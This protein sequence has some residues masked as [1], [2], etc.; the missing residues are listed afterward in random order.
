MKVKTNTEL[1]EKLKK[2]F[3]N[4]DK[5]KFQYAKQEEI[6]LNKKEIESKQKE[7]ELNK[8]EIE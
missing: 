1:Q 2:I 6:E 5:V 7:I 3:M 4:R 8:K